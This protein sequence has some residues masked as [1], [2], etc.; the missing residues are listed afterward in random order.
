MNKIQKPLK[1]IQNYSD[2]CI[3]ALNF[4]LER[5][6]MPQESLS[7][8]SCSKRYHADFIKSEIFRKRNTNSSLCRT[9][10]QRKK[11]LT[12]KD[13]LIQLEEDMKWKDAEIFKLKKTIHRRNEA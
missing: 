3:L 6:M 2:V 12:L 4:T 1:W 7:Y 9:G 8:F 13:A 10:R 5:A 11:I